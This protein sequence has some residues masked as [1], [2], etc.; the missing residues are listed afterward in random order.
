MINQ[1]IA[2]P[3]PTPRV[4]ASY[5]PEVG[6]SPSVNSGMPYPICMSASPVLVETNCFKMLI[7]VSTYFDCAQYKS[8]NTSLAPMNLL[9]TARRKLEQCS[10]TA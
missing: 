3:A 10:R 9:P 6:F 5:R 1:H 7:R 8:L 2:K 4:L